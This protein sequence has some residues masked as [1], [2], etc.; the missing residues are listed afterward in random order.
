MYLT[1]DNPLSN[2]FNETFRRWI[3]AFQKIHGRRFSHK[4]ERSYAFEGYQIY[5][6]ANGSVEPADLGDI[7]LAPHLPVRWRTTS[8]SW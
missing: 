1:N 6:L 4:V 3:Q 5:R 2:N 7:N 8:T